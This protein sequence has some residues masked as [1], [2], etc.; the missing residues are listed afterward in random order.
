MSCFPWMPGSPSSIRRQGLVRGSYMGSSVLA[1]LTHVFPIWFMDGASEG[2]TN[3]D[4]FS[5]TTETPH[6]R[7]KTCKGCK[8]STPPDCFDCVFLLMSSAHGRSTSGSDAKNPILQGPD[9]AWLTLPWLYGVQGAPEGHW[10]RSS[11][12][13]GFCF[14]WLQR[15]HSRPLLQNMF[16]RVQARWIPVYLQDHWSDVGGWLAAV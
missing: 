10:H 15:V 9:A 13:E 11:A 5:V 4:G 3:A 1:F 14:V 8:K 6:L 12:D 2:G 16:Y 7:V